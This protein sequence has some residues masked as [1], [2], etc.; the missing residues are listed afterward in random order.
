MSTEKIQDS[1]TVLNPNKN[2]NLS[3]IKYNN[4]GQI[5]NTLSDQNAV[6]LIFVLPKEKAFKVK[7]DRRGKLYNPLNE[8]FIRNYSLAAKDKLTRNPM[9]TFRTVSE[10]AFLNYVRFLETNT[11]TFLVIAEREI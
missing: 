1:I 7:V 5:D 2:S 6:A 11:V 9:F 4:K 3:I 10:A 8:E